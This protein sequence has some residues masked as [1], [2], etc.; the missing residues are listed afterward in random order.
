MSRMNGNYGLACIWQAEK[1]VAGLTCKYCGAPLRDN[2]RFCSKCGAMVEDTADEELWEE[3]PEEEDPFRIDYSPRQLEPE[4]VL[5]D[6][7]LF[8]DSFLDK[9]EEG[10]H[11]LLVTLTVL[12][13]IAS[14]TVSA[15]VF[16][17]A[18]RRRTIEVTAVAEDGSAQSDEGD[19]RILISDDDS[20]TSGGGIVLIDE[21]STEIQTSSADLTNAAQESETASLAAQPLQTE[22]PQETEGAASGRTEQLSSQIEEIMNRESSASSYGIFVY[23]LVTG[24]T[25]AAGESDQQMLSTATVTVPVLYTAALQLDQGAVTLNDPITYVNSVGGRGEYNGSERDGQS[26][27]LSFYLTTMLQ[28]SDN[29]C[30]NC[31]IDYFTLDAINSACRGNGYDSVDIQRKIVADVTDG[32]ENRISAQ[33]LTG[34]VR[35]LYNGRFTTIGR[36]FM[37]QNF[38][39][40]ETDANYTVIG[41][42]DALP[43]GITL[44]NQNGVGDTRYAESALI[45]DGSVSYILTV[46]CQGEYGYL[47][48]DAVISVSELVYQTLTAGA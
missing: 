23:N 42:A 43:D 9:S 2:D 3:I 40:D 7:K 10:S 48:K 18:E 35:D 20:Q 32:A 21:Y 30:I 13:L 1:G 31:L 14:L 46:M 8:K 26:Y 17:T 28:Y 36:D 15:L 34:M 19:G 25:Y 33:D 39:V 27:P 11:A 12:V 37:V 29:N 4:D 5:Y 41:L 22:K 16:M 44:L 24:D 38:H 45:T 47:F 6:K